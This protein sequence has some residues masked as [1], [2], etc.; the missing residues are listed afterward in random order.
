M[1]YY[2]VHLFGNMNIPPLHN[3]LGQAKAVDLNLF[4]KNNKNFIICI[5]F[6]IFHLG[7]T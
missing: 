7:N 2:I 3:F 4:K 6:F 1:L 5:V